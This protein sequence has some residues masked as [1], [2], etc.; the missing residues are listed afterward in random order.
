[1]LEMLSRL[2]LVTA[3]SFFP[4][5]IYKH[6]VLCW[7]LEGEASPP[8]FQSEAYVFGTSTLCLCLLFTV[9]KSN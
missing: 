9:G 6:R 5:L 7:F 1:M 3:L 4:D 8:L 2:D